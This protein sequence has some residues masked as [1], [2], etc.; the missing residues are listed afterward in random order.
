MVAFC[1]HRS[2]DMKALRVLLDGTRLELDRTPQELK[3]EDG[4][5]IEV[6]IQATGGS[7]MAYTCV[8][9]LCTHLEWKV[10][11]EVWKTFL[12]KKKRKEEEVWKTL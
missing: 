6:M 4:D 8:P 2:L 12:S 5:E 10:V 1:I 9:S 7:K 11:V 3:M